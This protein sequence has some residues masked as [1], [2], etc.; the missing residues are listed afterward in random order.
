MPAACPTITFE[1]H[2]RP[3]FKAHCF[4]CHGGEEETKGG[5]DL[6]LRRLMVGG[7]DSGPA[8]VPGKHDESLLYATRRRAAKCRRS[9]AS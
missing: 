4:R 2:V 3:I 5:L 6:R 9:I 7:G 1:Q 8:I